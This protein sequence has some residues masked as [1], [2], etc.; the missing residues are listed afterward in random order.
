M[1]HLSIL[2]PTKNRVHNI[3]RVLQSLI[4]TVS[5]KR[6]EEKFIEIVFFV[7]TDD[8]STLRYLVEQHF[9]CP[10][11][12]LWV[13]GQDV[14]FSDMW[15]KAY[16]RCSGDIVML[17]GDDVEFKTKDWDII[18]EQ[19]F[20][21][22]PDKICY[23]TV[24]DGYQNG[25]LGVHGFV[26][27]K[28]V[29]TVGF[30]TP[31]YF[32]YWYA[33]TWLDEVSKMIN[34]YIYLEN[35]EVIHYHPA[36]VNSRGTDE[37]YQ[38][39]DAKI[40]KELIASYDAMLGERQENARLLQQYID[41]FNQ[42]KPTTAI[43]LPEKQITKKLSILICSIFERKNM[44]D[45]L[46]AELRRQAKSYSTDVEILYEID[47]GLIATGTKRNELL[48]RSC[49]EYIVFVDDDDTVNES[50]VELILTAIEDKPDCV[51]FRGKIFWENDWFIFHNSIQNQIWSCDKEKK[52]MFDNI[53]H[54]NPIKRSIA[55]QQLFPDK[56]W[57]EDNGW[58]STV[59]TK[60]K[61]EKFLYSV[62]YHYTPSQQDIQ[63]QQKDVK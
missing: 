55:I 27:R 59:R 54:I 1:N 56:F 13:T 32:A 5:K 35:V 43:L 22:V 11:N 10:L 40:T 45:R 50:Y 41:D 20:E 28:W 62:M 53:S 23:I 16:E 60:L 37:V 26:H 29:E 12:L 52:T 9:S 4:E 33:D 34:R 6:I 25:A 46:I 48:R 31:P 7:D 63:K 24:R 38:R 61:R 36:T 17:C 49:G 58:L 15:N 14:L 19:R 3:E 8:E 57:G 30:F 42:T 2:I 18:V 47:G 51:G 21:A 39:N 44:F